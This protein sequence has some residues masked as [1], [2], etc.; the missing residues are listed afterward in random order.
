MSGGR[1]RCSPLPTNTAA[2]AADD[3]DDDDD[4][5]ADDGNRGV[6]A[7]AN[8]PCIIIP[9][10]ITSSRCLVLIL[11]VV[12]ATDMLLDRIEVFNRLQVRTFVFY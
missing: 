7:D 4:D 2:A 9:C 10:I 1:A 8:L 11:A 6:N 3:D 5:D 12:V